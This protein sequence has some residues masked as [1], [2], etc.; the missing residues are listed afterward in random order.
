MKNRF[1]ETK[2]HIPPW[3][4]SGVTRPRLL[5]RLQGGLNE[6]CKLTLV[7]APAGYGKTTLTAEWVQAI[8][9]NSHMAWL[10]L[11]E[12]DNDPARFLGYWI[13]AIH[14]V[15][16]SLGQSAQSLLGMP[17]TPPLESVLD[18]LINEMAGLKYKFVLVLD[19]Y[20]VITNPKL[21]EALEYFIEHQPAQLHLAMTTREDPPF[22]LARMRARGE[23]TEIRARDLRFTLEEAQQFF[24]Q[25]MHLNLDAEIVSALE[26]RTEGWATGLQLA[27]LALQNLSDRQEFISGFS[28]SHRYV[29][30]YLAEEVLRQQG[31]EIRRFLAQTSILERLTASLCNALTECNDSQS[32]LTRLEKSNLFIIPLDNEREWYRYHHLFADYLR[33]ELT[34][35]EMAELHK[36]AAIWHEENDLV[37][38]AVRYALASADA[39]FAADVIER[40]LDRHSTWSGGNVT[41]LSSWLDA[42]PSQVFQSR[43]R[44]GLNSSRVLYLSGRFELAEQRINE[45]E[46]TLKLM[47]DSLEREQMLALAALNRGSIA[48][49]RGDFQ[50]A[51]E[52][53]T[54]AQLRIP[55]ENHLAHARAFFSLGVAYEIAGQTDLAAQNYLHSSKEAQSTGVLF[56]AINALGAAAQI[57]IKQGHLHLA[58]Q[59]CRQAIRLAEGVRIAPLGLAWSLLGGIALERN[60]LLSAE[61]HLQDGIALSRQGGL[62]DDLV[63]GLVFLAR[64]RAYQGNAASAIAAIQEITSLMRKFGVPRLKLLAATIHARIELYLGQ[65]QSAMQWAQEYRTVRDE[66]SNEFQDLTFARVLLAKGELDTIPSILNPLLEKAT[67]AGR[68]QTCIEVMMLLGLFHHAKKDSPSALEWIGKSLRLAASEKFVRVFLDEGKPLLDLLP[69]ARSSAP[70]FVDLL[71][72][73]NQPEGESRSALI[74]QLP[75]PLSEQEIRVLKLIVG[76]KSNRQ[77][78]DELV[79]SVGTAKWHV[80]NILRKLGVGNRP[81]AIARARELGI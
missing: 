52:Q 66:L 72:G 74:E 41:L 29:L 3:R 12:S 54:F 69:K 31:E 75:D 68:M 45:T 36:K 32:I 62:V 10:S 57:Q 76:G 37:Y 60:D 5:Q 2:F 79:I 67:A 26:I 22:P 49:V 21:H 55:H 56:L 58:E 63:L 43:P 17:Q 71:L 25:S 44:L 34:K 38:E 39:D 64:L 13:A 35:P 40:A 33:T 70:E 42:L 9:D 11:D 23:L 24:D 51:I 78:A 65:P 14:R 1:L 53:T 59:S 18:E 50:Q 4:E 47:P 81:Q 77:I 7:S 73:Q 19:D 16:D 6:H 46:Q 20:H 48:S 30:D 27:A 80:H 8:T 28:G 15:D 61:R